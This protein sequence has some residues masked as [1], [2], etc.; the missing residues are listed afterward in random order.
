MA[1]KRRATTD[2]IKRASFLVSLSNMMCGL[3]VSRPSG[4]D[5]GR[6]LTGLKQT[7]AKRDGETMWGNGR[8]DGESNRVGRREGYLGRKVRCEVKQASGQ[9]QKPAD[10][11]L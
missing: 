7:K 2:P 5:L 1:R 11:R 6:F 4:Q 9:P 10:L 8:N 3:Q